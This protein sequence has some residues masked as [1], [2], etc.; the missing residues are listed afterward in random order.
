MKKK[1]RIKDCTKH[2]SG[3]ICRFVVKL[4]LALCTLII[5]F[6]LTG[7]GNSE[8]TLS[9]R[10]ELWENWRLPGLRTEEPDNALPDAGAE[11]L[12]QEQAEAEAAAAG[13]FR[14]D[15]QSRASRVYHRQPGGGEEIH[16]GGDAG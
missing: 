10:I 6:C 2:D 4:C 15:G 16:G 7:C 12:M 9:Q 8:L 5:L 14:A 11:A 1:M 3:Q 13:R